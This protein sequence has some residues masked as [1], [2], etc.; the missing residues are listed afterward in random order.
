M[1]TTLD[2]IEAA[3]SGDLNAR[4]QIILDNLGLVKKI[5]QRCQ[6]H[7]FEDAV[8]DGIF[9]VIRAIQGY[10]PLQS[11]FSTYMGICVQR[12]MQERKQN[13]EYSNTLDSPILSSADLEYEGDEQKVLSADNIAVETKDMTW[14]HEAIAY[15]EPRERLIIDLIYFHE[16]TYD[17]VGDILDIS[18][19][20]VDQLHK[21]AI[22]KLRDVL[23]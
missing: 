5:A 13:R 23:K 6:L 2:Q 12:A 22:K 8:Q 18:K 10:D 3:Q 7:R 11:G 20:R 16:A 19:Q 21:R 17:V 9:G 14:L 15:L 4:N 1:R